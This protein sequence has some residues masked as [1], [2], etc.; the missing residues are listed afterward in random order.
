MSGINRKIERGGLKLRY[1]QFKRAWA[2]EREKNRLALSM[3]GANSPD[4]KVPI[5]GRAP[6]FPLWLKALR[7]KQAEMIKASE[8]KVEVDSPEW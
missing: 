4:S 1:K 2:Q 3:P 7:N 6:P 8:K 5:I